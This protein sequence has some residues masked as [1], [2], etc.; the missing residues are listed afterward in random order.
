MEKSEFEPRVVRAR[1]RLEHLEAES[2]V[3]EERETAEQELRLVIGQ[4]EGFAQRVSE[5]LGEADW[6]TR[7]EVIRA[8]VK[9]HVPG[10]GDSYLFELDFEPPADWVYGGPVVDRKGRIVGVLDVPQPNSKT[11][12]IS[13]PTI[14]ARLAGE[15][16]LHLGHR[17]PI[18][19]NTVMYIYAPTHRQPADHLRSS[20]TLFPA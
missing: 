8:L 6:R 16:L 7:R 20:G 2:R 9:R 10:I 17:F 4:L 5:G 11:A 19:S 1:E 3:E 18:R 14:T 12:T 15:M 13:E